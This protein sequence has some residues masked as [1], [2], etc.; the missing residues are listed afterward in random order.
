MARRR[1]GGLV[2]FEG[3][4]LLSFLYPFFKEEIVETMPI[5]S[6]DV[7]TVQHF[8]V[9]AIRFLSKWIES[10]PTTHPQFQD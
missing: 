5:I 3:I 7:H 4:F 2:S 10:Y 1:R 8:K 9:A 6:I